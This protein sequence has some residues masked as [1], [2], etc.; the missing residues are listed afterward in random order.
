MSDDKDKNVFSLNKIPSNKSRGG[1]RAEVAVELPQPVQTA[2][3][4]DFIDAAKTHSV[5]VPKRPPQVDWRSLDPHE[6][7]TRGIN[8]RFNEY[9]LALFRHLASLQDR[10]IHQV[11]KRLLIPAA[12]QATEEWDRIAAE[13]SSDLR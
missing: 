7:P 6:R 11:I 9:E 1:Q 12:Q 10:S 3:A 13:Q 4:R 8:V 2:A 5:P